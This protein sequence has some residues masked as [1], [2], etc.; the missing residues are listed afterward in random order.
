MNTHHTRW[1]E[2]VLCH[3]II[4]VRHRPGVNNPVADGLS[5]M[6]RNRPRTNTDG[7]SWSVL[8]DWESS[9][10]MLHDVMQMTD[11]PGAPSHPL[12]TQFRGDI[13]F[14]P[15]IKHLLGKTAGDSI[16]DR[17]RAMH[18]AEGFMIEQDKLWRVSNKKTDRVA[19]TE[20]V[21]AVLGFQI[22]LDAHLKKGHFNPDLIKL[23]IRDRFFWPGLD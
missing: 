17:R 22:A 3:N 10:G 1:L 8:P 11:S 9:R 20:C 16:P 19:K 4:D 2:S 18:R 12:E 21:P 6:W 14:T 7:S 13:F 15:I 5:R 23:S